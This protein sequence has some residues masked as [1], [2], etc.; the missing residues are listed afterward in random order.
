MIPVLTWCVI[1]LIAGLLAYR[2][3]GPSRRGLVFTT[4]IGIVGAMLG[5]FVARALGIAGISGMNLRSLSLA[6]AGSLLVV[7]T[8]R[9]IAGCL[10]K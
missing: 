1:G 4:V 6:V 9:E 3:T 10:K 5:G 2:V 8:A 7:I